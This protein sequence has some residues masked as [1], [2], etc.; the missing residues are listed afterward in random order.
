MGHAHDERFRFCAAIGY[1]VPIASK[2]SLWAK[3]GLTY[4]W[5]KQKQSVS[6]PADEVLCGLQNF[7][8]KQH[9]LDLSIDP[10]LVYSPISSVGFLFGLAFDIGLSGSTTNAGADESGKLSSYGA[11]AGIALLL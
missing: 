9:Y 10:M 2:L 8:I 6:C 1:L 11:A 5:I 3:G 4:D 7:T